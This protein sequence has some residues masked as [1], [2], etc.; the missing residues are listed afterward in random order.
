MSA[1]LS[2]TRLDVRSVTDGLAS[3]LPRPDTATDDLR[4]SVAEIVADV[5]RRGDDALIELTERFDGVRLERTIIHADAIAAAVSRVDPD[6]M[7]SLAFAAERIRSYHRSQ[8]PSGSI[9]RDGGTIESRYRPVDAV[10]CYVPGGRA[11]YPSTLLMTAVPAS[12]AGVER[13]MVCCPPDRATGT[14]SDVT[15]AAA[16]VAGIEEVHAVGGAQAVAAMAHGTASISPVDVI[17]GPGNR[18]VALAQ[19]L[20]SDKVGI[21]AAFAGPS[22]I[23]VVAD[24]GV[25]VRLAAI[26]VL[27]Q[28]EHGPDGLA[29]FVTW[30]EAVADAVDAELR[31]LASELPRAA[32]IAA[33]L[34]SAGRIVLVRDAA[35]ALAVSDVV[36]PEHLQLMVEG[37][38]ALAPQVRNAGAIFIGP[39]SP[40]SV[41]D[42]LA[43]PSHVL[44]THGTARFASALGVADFLKHQ[45]IVE[46]DEQEFA[47][48]SPHLQRLATAEGLE[49]HALSASLRSQVLGGGES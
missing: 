41:G 35:Q 32:D 10:G 12:V 40:A 25:D 22:E 31:V 23:V 19:R 43:G 42:Y 21:A 48:V 18:Y 44:P 13:V 27:V 38:A 4:G 2:I 26:D 45:H 20:V 36:A 33:T 37:A 47:L 39:H 5:A 14:V 28:A 30:D 34:A 1:A 17:C 46:F 6:L 7:E 16:S 24:A 49:A 3:H 29:W 15:L 11:S 9:H 8:M